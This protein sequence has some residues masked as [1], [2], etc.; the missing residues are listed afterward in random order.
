MYGST[1]SLDLFICM[2]NILKVFTLLNNMIAF[3]SN[4]FHRNEKLKGHPW[5]FSGWGST[6]QC[7]GHGFHSWSGKIPHDQ[8]QL[9]LC[10]TTTGP[11]SPVLRNKRRHHNYWASMPC[12]Q[13]QEKTSQ[14]LG[15]HALCSGTREDITTTG[16]ACPVLR[17]KR[18]HHKEKSLQHS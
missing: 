12:A 13:E 6:C 8:E 1:K 16:P 5:C 14:L 11:A 9:S 4:Y 18:R 7:R 10:T 15:Q 2:D 17:N 3:L